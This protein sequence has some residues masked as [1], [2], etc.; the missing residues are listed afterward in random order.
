MFPLTAIAQYPE[1]MWW[2]DL[3]APSLGSAAVGDIDGDSLPEIVFGCYFNDEHI[4]ALNAEDGSLKWSFFTNGCNDA[5]PAIADVDQDG[6]LEVIVPA[7]SP[8]MVY[9]LNG[10][11]G[12]VE[13]DT[14]TGYGNCID[15]P[16]AIADVDND[17]KPEIVLGTFNG[18]VFCFNGE[19]GSVVWHINLGTNSA[20]ES[21]PN[22]VDLDRDGD[23][24]V[25]VAQWAGD[26]RVY[27]LDG[28]DGS[29]IWYSDVPMDYMYHGGS[30]ADI[31]SDGYPEIAIGCYDSYVYC[32]N[33]D[34]SLA[35][36]YNGPWYV[37]A[38]TCIA[39]LDNDSDYEIVYVSWYVVGALHH[40][41]SSH[42]WTFSASS[43]SF[44][45]CAIADIDGNDTL[46]VALGCDD[47]YLQVVRGNSGQLLWEI[48]LA[49]H[50]GQEYDID[51]GPVIAD[52]DSDGKLDIFVVGGHAESTQPQH[53]HGRAY[54]IKGGDGTGPGWPMFRHD[55]RHSAC[56]D[57]P[58][59]IAEQKI[60]EMKGGLKAC[61]RCYPNPMRGSVTLTY[62]NP[63]PGL[64]TLRIYDITGSL[65]RTLVEGE[66]AQDICLIRWDRR[67]GNGDVVPAGLYFCTLRAAGVAKTA[68]L[69]VI[70]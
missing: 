66:R 35:W 6:Q 14:T 49:S 19:D 48:D 69:T 8:S 12:T 54:A 2:Y 46:D 58:L 63:D 11:S 24:D 40:T 42:L 27:A 57:G 10:D 29:T 16:P 39:D 70:D 68:K 26:N 13:W 52:F 1:I 61:V 62:R 30:F 7:S 9:C 31:D 18:H 22:L 65:V 20:I 44:R 55:L 21:G 53:N 37:G 28:E 59:G 50:Y 36:S 60:P 3:D 51:H 15:S 47:G 32:F 67:D 56:F 5:S 45:G 25:L 43:G 33:D 64:V 38:P 17:G 4:Y 34:S 41:G 23:L